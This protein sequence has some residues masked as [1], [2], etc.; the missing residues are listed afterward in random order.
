MGRNVRAAVPLSLVELG[1]HN[2]VAWA[3]VYLLAKWHLDP[4][5]FQP[6]GHNTPTLQT[7]QT[8]RQTGQRSRSIGRTITVTVAQLL[9][10]LR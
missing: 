1:L 5:K 10:R 2:N 7:G 3:E 6:F 8:D 4:S 9:V